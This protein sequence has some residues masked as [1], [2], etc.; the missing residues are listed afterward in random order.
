MDNIICKSIAVQV[1]GSAPTGPP[2]KNL[3]PNPGGTLS[4]PCRSVQLA[5]LSLDGQVEATR[6]L[7][8]N[9]NYVGTEILAVQLKA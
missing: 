7:A 8:D 3:S 2:T 1:C 9:G 5:S 4:A 6:R